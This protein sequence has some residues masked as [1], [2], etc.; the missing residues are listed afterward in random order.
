MKI[1]V[2]KKG[3]SPL[4]RE[5]HMHHPLVLQA[6]LSSNI[7]FFLQSIHICGQGP[8]RH[9]KPA[10]YHGHVSGLF[11]SDGLYDMHVIVGDV[12]ILLRDDRLCLQS[13]HMVEQAHQQFVYGTLRILC[14]LAAAILL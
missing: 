10:G 5:G 8:Y 3:L 12:L 6:A 11:H 9:G 4:L 14:H 7:A 1:P 13:H 2:M